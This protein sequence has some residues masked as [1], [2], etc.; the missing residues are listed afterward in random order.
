MTF[1]SRASVHLF[2]FLP[3][4]LVPR[5]WYHH[6]L[7]AF[8]PNLWKRPT[9]VDLW[10]SSLYPGLFMSSNTF[11]THSSNK[12]RYLVWAFFSWLDAEW[13]SFVHL[14]ALTKTKISSEILASPRALSI[15]DGYF[16][17]IGPRNELDIP[18]ASYCH[19]QTICLSFSL[20]SLS[21]DSH[22]IRLC[23]PTILHLLLLVSFM[24]GLF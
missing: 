19:C 5:F 9:L 20:N 7:L 8:Q 23:C 24:S 2:Q 15:W 11:A 1:L 3:G 13:Y 21:L 16:P 12:R 10:V 17:P 18:F 22:A 6:L 14:P 4:G